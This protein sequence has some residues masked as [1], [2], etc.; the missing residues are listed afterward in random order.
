MAVN[1]LSIRTDRWEHIF[2]SFWEQSVTRR[3][4]VLFQDR[5]D[6]NRSNPN[7]NSIGEKVQ[8]VNIEVTS[9]TGPI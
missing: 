9:N 8:M 5:K 2:C 3:M 6:F 4:R 7:Q 1:K